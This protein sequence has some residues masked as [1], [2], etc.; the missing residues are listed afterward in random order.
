MHN[1]LLVNKIE[2]D[3][4]QKKVEVFFQIG[5]MNK[6]RDKIM[7]FFN[8]PDSKIYERCLYRYNGIILNIKIE[9][10][11]TLVSSLVALDVEIYSIFQPY[12]PI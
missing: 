6:V 4:S 7:D 2:M 11:P 9:D 12:K 3:D 10:I 1:T 5:Q 8:D